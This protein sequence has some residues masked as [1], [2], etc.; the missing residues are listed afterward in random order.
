[1][2]LMAEKRTPNYETTLSNLK[3]TKQVIKWKSFELNLKET[4]KE[5]TR[6]I[7]IRIK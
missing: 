4:N 6:I 1:M 7:S 3:K 2:P 5:K